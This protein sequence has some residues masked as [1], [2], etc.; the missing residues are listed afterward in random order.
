MEE[1]NHYL[2]FHKLQNKNELFIGNRIML[3]FSQKI[4]RSILVGTSKQYS[5]SKTQVG[6]SCFHN[7]L[8]S[9]KYILKY[10]LKLKIFKIKLWR[11]IHI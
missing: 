9:L 5:I 11:K 6:Y 7:S 3:I 4:E 8:I 2:G 10:I 1:S